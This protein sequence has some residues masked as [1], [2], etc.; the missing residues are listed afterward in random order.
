MGTDPIGLPR[1][2][3]PAHY[4]PAVTG[5]EVAIIVAGGLADDLSDG[6]GLAARSLD[7]GLALAKLNALQAYSNRRG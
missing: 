2:S 4:D 1:L 3:P 7:E 5:S 6:I